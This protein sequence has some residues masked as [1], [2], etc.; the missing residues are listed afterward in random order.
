VQ[1]AFEA[2]Y[3]KRALGHGAGPYFSFRS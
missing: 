1:D 2:G 3:Q